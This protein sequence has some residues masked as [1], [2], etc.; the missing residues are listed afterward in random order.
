MRYV[1]GRSWNDVGMTP[2]G[3]AWR[4]LRVLRQ[5]PPG[6]ARCDEDRRRLFSAAM[7][8]SEQFF[9]AAASVGPETRALLLFYG[10]SQSGR[11]LRAALQPGPD[12]HRSSGHGLTV[13]GD[14]VSDRL[15][16]CVVEDEKRGH[17]RDVAGT[18]NRATVPQ[19][20][21]V[22]ELCQLLQL[23]PRFT[24]DG[25]EP[26]H[27]P[28]KLK[29]A[30]SEWPWETDLPL[31]AELEVPAKTWAI[32]LPPVGERKTTHYDA[33]RAHVRERLQ[34]YPTLGDAQL[35]DPMEAH[36]DLGGAGPIRT[37]AITWPGRTP[38][39]PGDDE[40][41]LHEFSDDNGRSVL[42]YPQGAGTDL[43]VHPYLL[44]WVVLFAM[45]HH[46]RY[47]PTK[48]AAMVDVDHSD[49]AVAIEH[50]GEH[51]LDVLPELIHRTLVRAEP[52]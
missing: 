38:P 48:W 7:E 24:L 51:A 18:L 43:A 41:I 49:E 14:S 10:L 50:I 27:P 16:Q 15:A 37:V 42:I 12:W 23:G 29:L 34:H 6:L 22:G 17:F 40:A 31:R 35:Y 33:L 39:L 21:A 26:P 32:E 30:A 25:P 9:L 52:Q 20:Q 44:W 1:Y 45:A 28:L 19:G 2:R 11:A 3:T 13:K 5:A 46:V 8:Q 36:F 4:M 47:E